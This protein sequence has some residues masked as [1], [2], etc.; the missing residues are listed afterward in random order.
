MELL[1][2]IA[3]YCDFEDLCE[4]TKV[5]PSW[6]EAIESNCHVLKKKEVRLVT[7]SKNHYITVR[8][9]NVSNLD[10]FD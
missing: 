6:N 4:L 9:Q 10:T 7:I 2:E 1:L 5:S 3:K 8:N